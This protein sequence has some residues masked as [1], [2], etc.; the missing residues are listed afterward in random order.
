MK[1]GILGGTFNPMHFG[2]M[3]LAEGVRENLVL[4]KVIFIPTNIPP[5]K[6]K[7]DMAEAKDRFRM[8]KLAI[9]G[10]PFFS[11]S[12][13][14]IKR[15]GISYTIDTLKD[16]KKFFNDSDELFFIIGSDE[17]KD[18]DSWKDI[19]EV[20]KMVK[21]VVA[22]RPGCDLNDIPSEIIRVVIK[23][24]DISGYQIRKRLRENKSIRYLLPDKVREFILKRG[25]YKENKG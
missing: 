21:F 8:L 24:A 22:A 17:I 25:L 5:H 7:V 12:S 4:D 1:I 3:L 14:E 23:T 10:N 6:D 2:H 9:S 13:I 16:F 11:V 19:G 15:K 20:K 18:L